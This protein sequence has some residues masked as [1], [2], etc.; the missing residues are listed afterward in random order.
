[1]A[2]RA[3]RQRHPS[4]RFDLLTYLGDQVRERRDAAAGMARPMREYAELIPEPGIGALRIENDFPF[5]GE[6]YSEEVAHAGEV[7][8]V[9]ST[10]V[11][12]SAYAWRWAVRQ[13]DQYGET[14]IYIFPT[15]THVSE[16]GDERIEPAIEES[17]YL[18]TRIRARFVRHKKLKRIGRGFLHLRGSNSKAGA[19]SV[20]AQFIVFDEY[21][22]LDQQNLPQIERRI[23]GAKQLGMTPRVRR[24]GTPTVDGQGIAAAYESSDQRVWKVMCPECALAQEV[25]WE[26]NMRWTNPGKAGVMR[27]GHDDYEDVKEVERAWR[28]CSACEAELDVRE[29]E[30]VA[31]HPERRVIGFQVSRLIVPKTDLRQIILASR[32]TKPMEVEAFEN[33]D[34]GRPYSAVEAALDAGAIL[35]ASAL[36]RRPV[37]GYTGPH[38]VTMGVDVAGERNLSVRISEQLP[39]DS[40]DYPNARRALWIGEVESFRDVE[41]LM[42]AYRVAICAIDS[43]PERR[44][45]KTLRATFPGRVVLVEYD[46]R[47]ESESIKIETGEPG[48]PL[49]GVPL[50][51]RVNRTESIDAMMDSIRQQRNIPLA[52]PP[53]NYVAQLRAPKRKTVVSNAGK[54]S[55]VYVSGGTVGDDYAHAEVY[56]LVAT[57]L[58]RMMRGIMQMQRGEGRQVPDEQIGF[59]RVR[60][61]AGDS[62]EYRRGFD[63]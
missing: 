9:K 45:A 32:S 36:G 33:N 21:D 54:V 30:W 49:E 1:M 48:T 12:M 55:R 58:W 57:E 16:F 37:R 39:A 5:Q 52:D 56:D 62:D 38:Q 41:A 59:K 2:T 20:A 46:A 28:A 23:T 44:M 40:P 24:I 27:A 25:T 13:T 18:Q 53:M 61:S 42:H 6:W 15:D 17:Q 34:L 11:G 3:L 31:Q 35:A 43:N 47:N 8:W 51:V 29:G 60:L 63:G 7:V 22:F 26:E 19:Q 10:Q 4:E 50:K 14:G